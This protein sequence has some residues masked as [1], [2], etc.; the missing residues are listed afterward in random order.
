MAPFDVSVLG[1]LGEPLVSVLLGMAFGFVLER[2]GFGSAKKLTSQ[3]YL[4]DMTVLKVMFTA[5]VTAMVLVLF[6]TTIGILDYDRLFVNPTYLGSGILGGLIFGVGFVIGG[7]CP[8]T[9]LVAAATLKLDGLLFVLGVLGGI[10]VFGYTVPEIDA[11][12]ND[13]GNYGV[14]TLIDWLG[15]PMPVVVALAVALAFAFFAGG[16]WIEAWMRRKRATDTTNAPAEGSEA[17]TRHT[18]VTRH[19]PILRRLA[20]ALFGTTVVLGLL[21]H[22]LESRRKGALAARIEESIRLRKVQVDPREL[23]D[24]YSEPKLALVVLDLRSEAEYNRFHLLD[25][26]HLD[27]TALSVATTLPPKSIKVLVAKDEAQELAAYR[28]LALARVENLYVLAGGMPSWM[29]LFSPQDVETTRLL[30]LGDKHVASR[31]PAHDSS[32]RL[33]AYVPTVKRP[34]LGSKKSGGGCGG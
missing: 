23:A 13:S 12:W 16:E 17:A 28:H 25:A 10:F 33:P 2:S 4:D 15:L 18:P 11:F 5:I 9:A 6:A 31:S 29:R 1:R 14:L 19:R 22:P 20:I 32:S 21:W 7:F 34:G 26:K 8:G 27:A 30:A 24:L 3:F